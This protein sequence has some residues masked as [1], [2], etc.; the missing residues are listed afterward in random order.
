MSARVTG[1]R[2][3]SSCVMR[4][5]GVI[6]VTARGGRG[7]QAAGAVPAEVAAGVRVVCVAGAAEDAD[8][9]VAG[10]GEQARRGAGAD[11]A[12]VFAVC[13]VTPVVDWSSQCSFIA[14]GWLEQAVLGGWQLDTQAFPA[15]G[16]DAGGAEVAALDTLQHG[17]AGDAEGGGGDLGG[18]P[19]GGGV[20]GDEGAHGAGEADPP[21]GAGSDL[22]AGDVSVVEPPVEG[23]GGDAEL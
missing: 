23:G 14:W 2:P 9:Q 11:G 6:R 18:D 8:D 21:G 16:A 3:K 10:G 19:S 12:G 5:H 17:L 4:S 15:S 1:L 20:V 22:L 13:C 7:A